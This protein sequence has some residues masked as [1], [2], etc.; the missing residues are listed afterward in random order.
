MQKTLKKNFTLSGITLHS[1]EIS[2]IKVNPAPANTG[3]LF[4]R[5]DLKVPHIECLLN[6][7][8]E[9]IVYSELCTKLSN[10]YGHSVSTIEH[11][12]SAFHGLG[13]DNAII[14]IDKAELP[15]L[16]GSSLEYVSKIERAGIKNL[17]AKRKIIN[18]AQP[19]TFRDNESYIKVTPS[20]NMTINYTIVY[21]HK[22]I[23][24]QNFIFDL[25][26]TGNYRNIISNSR[27]FG[28]KDE[29]KFLRDKGLIAGGSLENAIVLDDDGIINQSV[30]RH[31]DEFVRHKV[32]DFIGDI[33]LLGHRV[34]GNFEIFKGGH[35]LTHELVKSIKSD[36]SNWKYEDEKS[37]SDEITPLSLNH[38]EELSA[39]L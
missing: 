16:D 35:R 18:I 31:D 13:I 11:L 4:K 34:K 20:I 15:I 26:S 12:M 2:N 9:N 3:I 37:D 33:Y 6:A 1:G 19:I 32:L 25:D 22:L 8:I 36:R 29:I 24:E 27:T 10:E 39:S 28:F 5:T 23:K 14:E 30:L 7:R 21:D 17:Q 38:K